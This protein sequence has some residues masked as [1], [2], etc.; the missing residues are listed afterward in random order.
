[1]NDNIFK[2]FLMIFVTG[3]FTGLHV[4]GKERRGKE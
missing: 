4:K 1:M 3:L 2:S